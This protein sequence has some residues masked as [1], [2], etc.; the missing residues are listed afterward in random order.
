VECAKQPQAPEN[1]AKRVPGYATKTLKYWTP[2]LLTP[3]LHI[4][5]YYTSTP[6]IKSMLFVYRPSVSLTAHLKGSR[7]WKWPREEDS[8]PKE[9]SRGEQEYERI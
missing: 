2:L 3:L 4:H 7:E 8:D 9:L 5:H 6:L 1:D